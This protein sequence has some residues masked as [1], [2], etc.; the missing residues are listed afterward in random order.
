[1]TNKMLWAWMVIF[2][3]NLSIDHINLRHPDSPWWFH[4]ILYAWDVLMIYALWKFQQYLYKKTESDN[5]E[6]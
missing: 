4:L 2:Y 6:R 3:L 1:M 5:E